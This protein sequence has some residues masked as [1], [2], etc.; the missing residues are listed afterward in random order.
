ML[1]Q[2]SLN[3]VTNSLPK[4]SIIIPNYNHQAYIHQRLETI[5]TQTYTDWEAIIID[6][7]STDNSI[8]KIEAYLNDHPDFKVKHFI[9][10]KDNSGSG[11]KSWQKGIALA[12]TSYIWIAETDDFANSEFLKTTVQALEESKEAALAFTA[13]NYVNEVGEFLYNSKARTKDLNVQENTCK[14]FSGNIFTS[15]L[16]LNPYI[17]NAS[18]V[19]FKKPLQ[20]IPSEI[21]SHKQ[22]SDLFLWTYL[23]QNASFVFCNST[24]NNFRQHK[25]STTFKTFDKKLNTVYKE[26]VSYLNYFNQEEKYNILIDHYIKHYVW[27]NKSR[28]QEVKFLEELNTSANVKAYYRKSLLNYMLNKI[29][30]NG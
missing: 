5:R 18:S 14:N 30:K 25:G 10:N 13:S 7:A 22:T 4:V 20:N 2:K 19:L 1:G 3:L 12:E 8:Y 11:Y 26:Y 27:K 9:K 17:T 21:F 16:P 23:L 24:L 29:F 28:I 6:D 15:R